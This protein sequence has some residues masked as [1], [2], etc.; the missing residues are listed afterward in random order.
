MRVGTFSAAG[1]G[2]TPTHTPGTESSII[3][4]L[5]T[6]LTVKDTQIAELKAQLRQRAQTI[7]VLHGELDKLH[8]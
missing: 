3:A 8:T 6:R 4:A 1:W 5:R 7:E 2:H